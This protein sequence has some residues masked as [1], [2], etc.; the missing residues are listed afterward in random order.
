M[1]SKR[2][3]KALWKNFKFKYKLSVFNENTLEEVIGIRV[4]K[5]NG[6]SVLLSMLAVLFLIAACI[7]A[8]TPLRNYLPGYVNSE[9]RQQIVDN[10]LRADS[11]QIRLNRQHLYILNVQDI[12][13]GKV[14]IDSVQ[15][16]EELT[17]VRQ[18]SLMNPTEREIAFRKEYEEKEKYNLYTIASQPE[19]GGL[20][21][22]RPVRGMIAE[23]F[24][25]K[26]KSPGIGIVT[27]SKA[28]VLSTLEGRVF[29]STYTAEYGYVIGIQHKQSF[30]S[31]YKH[32]GSLLKQAGET[33]KVGEPIAL[34]G[35]DGQ[36]NKGKGRLYME[37]WRNGE[38]VNP[39]KYI[40]F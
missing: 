27:S 37:L 30:M 31:V 2:R 11:L 25:P 10:A 18:D 1:L 13:S 26:Q 6:L 14:R 21:F 9:V 7:V 34:A 33:V 39:E 3:R 4:S 29:L 35:S 5:L 20:V 17:K 38:P 28:A 40:V 32:C 23:S 19:A 16:V 12:L 22:Y 8:F 36:T 24:D 15:S